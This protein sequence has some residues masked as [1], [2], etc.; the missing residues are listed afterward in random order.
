[1]AHGAVCP[2][3]ALS[4]PCF[5]FGAMGQQDE[6]LCHPW[7]SLSSDFGRSCFLFHCFGGGTRGPCRVEVLPLLAPLSC[8]A[9][10]GIL[11]GK[12]REA[13]GPVP[14]QVLPMQA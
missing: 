10:P 13:T 9:A 12:R 8:R 7:L 5:C 3:T 6:N 2:F 1:M 4:L 14:E 11:S